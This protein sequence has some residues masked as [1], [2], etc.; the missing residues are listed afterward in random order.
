M[1]TKAS[2]WLG[3]LGL[4]L[5][6]GEMKEREAGWAGFN[7]NL[8]FFPKANIKYRNIFDFFKSFYES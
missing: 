8:I 6:H 5:G 4:Q 3:A 7:K 2:N 1:R